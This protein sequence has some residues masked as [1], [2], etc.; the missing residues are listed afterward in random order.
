LPGEN[1]PEHMFVPAGLIVNGGAN[2][3]VVGHVCM[4]SKASWEV[5]S[6]EEDQ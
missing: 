5:V 3:S 4:D 1:D 6:K 2:L